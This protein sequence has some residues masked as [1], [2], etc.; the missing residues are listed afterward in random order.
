MPAVG[1]WPPASKR[2][3]HNFRADKSALSVELCIDG[4]FVAFHIDAADKFLALQ[5]RK[6]VVAIFAHSRRDKDFGAIVKTEQ[7]QAALAVA[8]E[9]IEGREYAHSLGRIGHVGQ[10]V[11]QIG[12]GKC[13]NSF[14]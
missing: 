1:S 9:G 10:A 7:A 3:C 12:E 11:G 4:V 2:K 8:D 13:Q 6:H 5:K 14:C